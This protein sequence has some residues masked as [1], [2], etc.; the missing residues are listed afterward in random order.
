ME[1]AVSIKSGGQW[2]PAILTTE[3]AA[4]SYGQPVVVVDGEPHGPAEVECV[5]CDH[6]VPA[7]LVDAAVA[8]GF[9]VIGG[10]GKATL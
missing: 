5:R 9:Y 6:R 4:S 3:H 1:S 2:H 8:A 10:P 7:E